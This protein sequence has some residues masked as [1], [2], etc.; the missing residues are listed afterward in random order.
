MLVVATAGRLCVSHVLLRM[1]NDK[2][3]VILFNLSSHTIDNKKN[4]NLMIR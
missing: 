1:H 4:T 2:I 3:Y